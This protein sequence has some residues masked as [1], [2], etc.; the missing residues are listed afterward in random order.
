MTPDNTANILSIVAIVVSGLGVAMAFMMQSGLRAEKRKL[1]NLLLAR[2]P[3]V[4]ALEAAIYPASPSY[5]VVMPIRNHAAAASALAH[6]IQVS[7][8]FGADNRIVGVDSG[9]FRTIGESIGESSVTLEL[10]VLPPLATQFV[11]VVIAKHEVPDVHV[12]WAE[13]TAWEGLPIGP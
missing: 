11:S 10:G 1:A 13:Q 7:L 9:P 6:R 3:R 12:S 2:T 5:R 8:K 4:A